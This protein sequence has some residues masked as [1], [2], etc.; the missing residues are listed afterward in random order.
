LSSTAQPLTSGAMS[1]KYT[2]LELDWFGGELLGRCAL[3]CAIITDRFMVEQFLA[4]YIGLARKVEQ[5]LAVYIGLARKALSHTRISN[6][7]C[8][9]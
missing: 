8:F 3:Y 6:W 7:T 2:W 4:A 9:G 5:F 1:D